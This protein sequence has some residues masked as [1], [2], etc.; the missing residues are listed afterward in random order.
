MKKKT[1]YPEQLLVGTDAEVTRNPVVNTD[2]TPYSGPWTF[3]QATHLLR[4]TMYGP[5]Y[6]QIKWSVE[7]GLE[8]TL[9]HLF[10]PLPLPD[11]PVNHRYEQD[12]VV[13]V[14]ETWINAPYPD[15]GPVL[16]ETIGYRNQSL[17]SWTMGILTNEGISIREKLTLF[18]H[19]HFPINSIL[20]AKFR[21]RYIH[22]LRGNALGNFRELV[23]AITIDPSMLRVLDGRL[24]NREAPNENYARELLELFTIGKGPQV[25]P[26]DY[27]NYTEQDVR[28]IARALTGWIDFGYAYT[29]EIPDG[30]I[31]ALYESIR[32]DTGTKQLSHRFG[33]AQ[34]PNLGDQEYAYV[35]DIIFQQPEVARFICRKLYQW[36]IY[37]EIEPEA[38]ANVIEPMAQI[39]ID[40][41]YEIA[42]AVR[43]LLSSE[44]FLDPEFY[45]VM[46]KNPLDFM[47]SAIKPLEIEISQDL[48]QQYDSWYGLFRYPT[49]MQMEYY[50]I[51]EV[52]G[53]K[54]Y[55]REPLC[56][57]NW[58]SST[59][60]PV[61]KTV[62]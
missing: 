7:Q 13:P 47:M 44:H 49:L 60:L 32:H 43:A 15:P 40:N 39:L 38:E 8:A 24:N 54:A 45:G 41:D 10:E 28:E 18:W 35:V 56:Y 58:I 37:Y 57:R 55:Y 5:T 23:K 4:R 50:H 9:D 22:L 3:E 27:S 16:T 26:G 59:T 42:P 62:T 25:S 14:G 48:H 21:Y 46:I 30:S 53:W 51:P 34:I 52:A 29:P 61:R 11:P 1:E 6:N 12:P 33:H 36:F 2:L 31:G 17:V 20:D 19:N